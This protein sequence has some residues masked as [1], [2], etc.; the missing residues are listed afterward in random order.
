MSDDNKYKSDYLSLQFYSIGGRWGYAIMRLE[1]SSKVAKV[2]LAK[3][4]KTEAF[5]STKKY[6]W[7]EVPVAHVNDFSQVQKIN[8]KHTDNFSNIAEKITKELAIIKET[9]EA[10]EKAKEEQTTEQK[11]P[12]EES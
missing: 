7:E 5:P 11:E 8:F 1:D 6:E 4:K 10:K 3:C 2:R 9:E 12:Q